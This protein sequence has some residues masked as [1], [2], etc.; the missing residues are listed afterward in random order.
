MASIKLPLEPKNV[1]QTIKNV[2]TWCDI[3]AQNVFK[4]IHNWF[5]LL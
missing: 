2:T 1:A 5:F 4:S 3:Q